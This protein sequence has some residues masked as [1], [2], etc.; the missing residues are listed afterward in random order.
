MRGCEH[1]RENSKQQ[2]GQ[3]QG[4]VKWGSRGTWRAEGKLC[5]RTRKQVTHMAFTGVL[6]ALIFKGSGSATCSE[7]ILPG[8]RIILSW[9]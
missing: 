8:K 6:F 1:G 5:P 2:R 7:G 3:K 4:E 9:L